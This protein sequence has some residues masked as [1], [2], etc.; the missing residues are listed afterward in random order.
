LV[1]VYVGLYD[2]N[3]SKYNGV[4]YDLNWVIAL[5]T[6]VAAALL[7]SRPSSR[8]WVLL[9]G[10]VW[11][12]V[13]I[14]SLFADASTKLCSGAPA[15]NCWPST[16]AAFDYLILNEA[17]ISGASGYG[18]K[19]APVIPVAIALLVVVII[20]SLVG[21]LSTKMGRS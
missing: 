19:L 10:V 15:S 1:N 20:L 18:W 7:L 4:H 16:S 9:A 14:I 17:N 8:T 5:V 13:Y 21:A 3:L 12:L 2:T 11:P 6:L